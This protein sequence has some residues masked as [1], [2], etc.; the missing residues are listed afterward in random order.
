MM[1]V[2]SVET[3]EMYIDETEV[4]VLGAVLQASGLYQ[5][6]ARIPDVPDGDHAV[7][8]EVGGAESSENVSITIQR[9]TAAAGSS[10]S[11]E[12]PGTGTGY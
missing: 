12:T 10:A 9:A 3:V 11:T 6:N 2:R 4:E 1:T 5:I 8:I 7:R